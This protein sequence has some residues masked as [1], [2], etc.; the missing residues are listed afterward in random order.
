[1]TL[2]DC[3]YLHGDWCHC[4]KFDEQE[5]CPFYMDE[6]ENITCKEYK[7]KRR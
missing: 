5:L 6:P 4:P 7:P 3:K 1:M 2:N